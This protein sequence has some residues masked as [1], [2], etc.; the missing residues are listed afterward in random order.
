MTYFGLFGAPGTVGIINIL[1]GAKVD[2]IYVL[3]ALRTRVLRVLC[4]EFKSLRFVQRRN[5]T[6]RVRVPNI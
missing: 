1:G 6:Q 2:A 3:G 4:P 5:P